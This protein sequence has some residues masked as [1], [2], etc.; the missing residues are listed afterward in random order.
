MATALIVTVTLLRFC[1]AT[2]PTMTV[3]VVSI[4]GGT[5]FKLA[6]VFPDGSP[7]KQLEQYLP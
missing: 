6:K 3:T 1:N 7:A 4:Q 5:V 2:T